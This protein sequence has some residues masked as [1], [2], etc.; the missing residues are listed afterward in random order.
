MAPPDDGGVVATVP[1][2]PPGH[3]AR[4]PQDPAGGRPSLH[5]RT[6]HAGTAMRKYP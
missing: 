1:T 3:H 4:V 6:E 2:I 5:C